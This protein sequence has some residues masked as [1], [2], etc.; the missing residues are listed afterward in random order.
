MDRTLQTNNSNDRSNWVKT[1]QCFYSNVEV[2]EKNMV[3][4]L[5]FETT[6]PWNGTITKLIAPLSQFLSTNFFI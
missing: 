5:T 6:Y 1:L 2:F 4:D 3:V